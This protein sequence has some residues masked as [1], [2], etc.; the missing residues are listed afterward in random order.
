MSKIVV[1]VLLVLKE[2]SEE[3]AGRNLTPIIHQH[4]CCLLRPATRLGVFRPTNQTLQRVER[5]DPGQPPHRGGC[6]GAWHESQQ[7]LVVAAS[8]DQ[9]NH[10]V[11][12]A[13]TV[14]L[15]DGDTRDN[16]VPAAVASQDVVS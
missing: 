9:R 12:S 10:A 13:A 16:R 14:L 11:D 1:I 15:E 3:I 5:P 6:L 2:E 4:G 7:S 8:V